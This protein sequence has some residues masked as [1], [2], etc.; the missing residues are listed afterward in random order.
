[1]I[2]F[3]G[4]I[5]NDQSTIGDCHVQ[6]LL[7]AI[8]HARDQNSVACSRHASARKRRGRMATTQAYRF[9][10]AYWIAAYNSEYR[11][12]SRQ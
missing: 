4:W 1:M 12:V 3:T 8:E 6:A 10:I 2:M 11:K 5:V 7:T 9:G